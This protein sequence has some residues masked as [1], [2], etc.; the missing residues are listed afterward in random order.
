MNNKK[1]ICL[2][3]ESLVLSFEAIAKKEVTLGHGGISGFQSPHRL[4]DLVRLCFDFI[5]I[6]N[7]H[8]F[9]N[10]RYTGPILA[11]LD[12]CNFGD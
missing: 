12:D 8:L 5:Q 10:I 11:Y 6:Y 9:N 3:A 4:L 1:E 2:K 7:F